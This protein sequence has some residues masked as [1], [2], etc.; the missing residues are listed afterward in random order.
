[1]LAVRQT[2]FAATSLPLELQQHVFDFLDSKSFAA[3]RN[4]CRSWRFAT[5]DS[6]TLERQLRKLPIL[7]PADVAR[8]SPRNLARLFDEATQTLMLGMRLSRHPDVPQVIDAK[9]RER[10]G[11]YGTSRGSGSVVVDGGMIS[12][13]DVSLDLPVPIKQRQL[14]EFEGLVTGSPWLNTPPLASRYLALSHSGRLLAIARERTIQII[15]MLAEDNLSVV[16]TYGTW[17]TGQS[18]CGL[19]FE[20]NDHLLRVSWSD[21]GRV[22]YYGTPSPEPAGEQWADMLHCEER[23]VLAG[24]QLL[25]N[26]HSGFMFAAQQHAGGQRSQYVYGHIQVTQ[27]G[28]LSAPIA[29]CTSVTI[30]SRLDSFLSSMPYT[31]GCG[32]SFADDR[33]LWENMPSAHEHHPSF[34]LSGDGNLLLLA[35]RSKKEIRHHQRTQLFVYRLPSSKQAEHKLEDSQTL[36]P[37]ETFIAAFE[38]RWGEL[39]RRRIPMKYEDFEVDHSALQ[40]GESGKHRIGRIPICLGMV[41]GSVTDL[42]FR[43]PDDKGEKEGEEYQVDVATNQSTAQWSLIN[44]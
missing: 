3:V 10:I 34:T 1:M 14:A 27:S 28:V 5:T 7:P 16:H 33:G 12:L 32:G 30:L 9:L 15:D 37:N 41:H 43:R 2:S 13:Y 36:C 42:A 24:V 35:E 39:K 31:L 44:V 21:R 11:M 19:A 40:P 17:A 26:A 6:V 38:A 18:I 4:V 25:R 22:I 20:Q 8:E 23:P 29:D